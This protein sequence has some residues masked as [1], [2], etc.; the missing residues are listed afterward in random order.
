MVNPYLMGTTLLAA[1][2]DGIDNKLDPGEPEER[3]IYDAI[4]D[5]KE[6]KKLPMSL[7]EALDHLDGSEVVKRGMPGEMHRLFDEYKRDEEA[8][9]MSTV[10]EWDNE[11]Y[12][13]C[14]P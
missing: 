2:D 7:G 3:N 14:L 4:A 6:V 13:E 12:M 1:M 9:F 5:G 8:R 10:T 11:T